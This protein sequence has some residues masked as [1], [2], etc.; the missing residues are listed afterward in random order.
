MRR[1]VELA[2]VAERVHAAAGEE[3][4]AG[5][6]RI[7]ARPWRRRASA[8][9]L[10]SAPSGSVWKYS[11]PHSD[12]RSF[13]STSTAHQADL[14]HRAEALVQL[15]D[16]VEVGHQRAQLGGRAQVE[17]GAFVDV[18]RL[19][20]VV[21]LHAQVVDV[22]A[23]LHQR[24]AVDHLRRVA[25]AEHALAGQAGG[26]RRVRRRDSLRSAA[27]TAC[28][29][30]RVERARPP[31]GR[32]GRR[33]TGARRRAGS[34]GGCAPHWRPCARRRR[35]PAAA[36]RPCASAGFSLALRAASRSC[37]V[38]TPCLRQHA[39]VAVGQGFQVVFAGAQVIRRAALGDHQ[40]QR[41]LV[42][43]HGVRTSSSGP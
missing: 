17:L 41:L 8:C 36:P 1:V 3:A 12:M 43:Q 28:W 6:G 20:V 38:I 9:R 22:L 40:R 13:G 18:Q 34:P 11:R 42:G 23:P 15:V 26:V 37:G 27:V 5:I 32:G 19:V 31:T 7:L 35:S 4:F 21:G 16:D 2:E 14:V 30:L 10:R 25:I 39:Q 29:A 33:C 24:E